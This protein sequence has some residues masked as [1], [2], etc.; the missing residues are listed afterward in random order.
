[1]PRTATAR[2]AAAP[3]VEP[4]RIA[5]ECEGASRTK[6]CPEFLLG[7]IE[8]SPLFLA[9]PRAGAQVTLHVAAVPI[10]NDDRI[11]LRFVGDVRGAPASIEVDVDV[12]TRGT[13]DEQRA[14]LR[15][16]F[17]RGVALY[18][19]TIHPEAVKIELVEPKLGTVAAKGTSPWGVNLDLSGDGNWTE[20][21]QSARGFAGAS[22]YRVSKASKYS[23]ELGA[24]GG[25][26]R[27][28]PL[29]VDDQ[30]ISLDT[31]EWGTYSNVFGS[32]TLSPHF[33]VASSA[34]WSMGDP[35]GQSRHQLGANLGLEWDYYP[36]DEPRGNV[37]A[38][39][40]FV[41]LRGEVYNYPNDIGQDSAIFPFNRLSAAARIRRDKTTFGLNLTLA[42][43]IF[44]P[45]RRHDL[46]AS[47]SIEW[48]IG[49]HVDIGLRFS[50]GKRA[51]PQPVIP[52]DDYEAQGRA[53]YA[54]PL[55]ISGSINLRI[56]FDPTNGVRNNRFENL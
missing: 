23:L 5:L 18:V 9:S 22:I 29:V 7:F 35:K 53:A 55:Y 44:H 19:A 43:E 10:A 21:F 33:A 8:A 12:N 17:L 16:A 36:S 45:T 13:D 6:V 41:A 30:E 27:R 25:F 3:V 31:S 54:Q 28:P 20:D 4:L 26:S 14:Q 51:V 39:A 11:H 46:S 40:Y 38:V 34:W 2:P 52:D 24:H 56:H 47:P 15:P 48:Q 32:R 49:D 37:L 42:A 1:M 50:G